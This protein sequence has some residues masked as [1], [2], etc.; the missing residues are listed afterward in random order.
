VEDHFRKRIQK[1]ACESPIDERKKS[2]DVLVDRGSK[3]FF[4]TVSK[5]ND[6]QKDISLSA[7]A[8]LMIDVRRGNTKATFFILE[9]C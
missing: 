7:W 6:I 5:N 4:L 2:I 9:F 3:W 8:E 1:E